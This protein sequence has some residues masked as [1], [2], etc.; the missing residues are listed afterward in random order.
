MTDFCIETTAIHDEYIEEYNKR[1]IPLMKKLPNTQFI[2]VTTNPDLVLKR[3]N[4]KVVDIKKYTDTNFVKSY[5]HE[6]GFCEI[7]Q[8]TRFGLKEAHEAGYLKVIHLQTD[9][10]YIDVDEDKL[11]AHFKRGL[12]FDMGGSTLNLKLQTHDNKTVYLTKKYKLNDRQLETTP[13]GDDPVVLFKFK[14]LEEFSTYLNHL[15]DVCAETFSNPGF[16]TGIADELVFAMH[17]TGVRSYYDYHGILHRSANKY[18][19][20][21]HGHLHIKHY[22]DRDVTMM[23]QRQFADENV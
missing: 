15:D 12:Y 16:T 20:V 23:D 5:S 4:L 18:F 14:S 10:R 9:M 7:L 11:S 21:D 17:L 2:C 22:N 13:V 1:F 19:D 6:G 8:A 3:D